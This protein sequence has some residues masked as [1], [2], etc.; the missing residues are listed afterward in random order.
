[1]HDY[2]DKLVLVSL[3]DPNIRFELNTP[4]P[5]TGAAPASEEWLYAYEEVLELL[6]YQIIE[7]VKKTTY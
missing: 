3:K 7:E 6:G 1:M 4:V 2:N 5:H